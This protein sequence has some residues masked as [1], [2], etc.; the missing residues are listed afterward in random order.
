[1]FYW[2]LSSLRMAISL[3]SRIRLISFLS[4]FMSM[5]LMATF[6][7]VSSQRPV[8]T[9][10]EQP[11]PMT[12]ARPQEQFSIFLRV[13][14]EVIS[15]SWKILC[16]I[17]IKSTVINY[18]LNYIQLNTTFRTIPHQQIEQSSIEIDLGWDGLVDGIV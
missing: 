4:I 15:F 16:R 6:W 2:F 17:K 1:M 13:K 12:S 14:L 10:L 5:T 9:W 3:Q 11:L 18:I 7:L 8:Q